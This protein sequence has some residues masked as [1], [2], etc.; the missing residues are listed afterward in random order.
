MPELATSLSGGEQ[1]MDGDLLGV[2]QAL[3]R[4]NLLLHGTERRQAPIETLVAQHRQFAFG[5]V[6]PT[7]VLGRVMKVQ[8]A[9][10]AARFRCREGGVQRTA[11]QACGC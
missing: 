9:G 10:D 4:G 3:P 11:R 1:P 2:A 7:A 5:D 6:Q 8:L